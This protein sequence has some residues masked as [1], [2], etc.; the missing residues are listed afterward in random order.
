M[1]INRGADKRIFLIE[2]HV[3]ARL[4]YLRR[5]GHRPRCLGLCR[6][7]ERQSPWVV[8]MEITEERRALGIAK[9]HLVVEMTCERAHQMGGHIAVVALSPVSWEILRHSL[10]EIAAAVDGRCQG[11]SVL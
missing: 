9:E 2:L 1:F 7:N 8:G 4:D 6:W 5:V 11:R 3:L 10:V